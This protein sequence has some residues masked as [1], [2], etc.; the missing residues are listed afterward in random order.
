MVTGAHRMFVNGKIRFGNRPWAVTIMGESLYVIPPADDVQ[1][2]CRAPKALDFD[3]F[4]KEMRS[5]YGTTAD[6]ASKM[7]DMSA[8]ESKSWT[9]TIIKSQDFQDTNASRGKARHRPKAITGVR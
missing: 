7:F 9:E 2:V 5:L 6:T 3:P 8:G 1:A 4:I